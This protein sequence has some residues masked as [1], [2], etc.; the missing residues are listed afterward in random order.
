MPTQA[1]RLAGERV[2]EVHGYSVSAYSSDDALYAEA[3][4]VNHRQG[5]TYMDHLGVKLAVDLKEFLIEGDDKVIG[6]LS[7]SLIGSGNDIKL[8]ADSQALESSLQGDYHTLCNT[9]D[10]TLGV[11][12]INLVHQFLGA[13]I[14]YLVQVVD[15]FYVHS[16]RYF[17]HK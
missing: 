11:F 9:I 2:I 7:V 15:K 14:L 4:G 12:L 8:V 5:S 1:H 10:D 6:T 17:I 13:V 16:F 3:I